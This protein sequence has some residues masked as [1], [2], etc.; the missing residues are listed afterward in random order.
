MATIHGIR[1]FEGLRDRATAIEVAGVP[2]LVAALTDIIRSKRAAGR[3]RD[4]AVLEVLEAARE[5]A[6]ATPS[7]RTPR[8]ARTR[9]SPPAR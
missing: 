9:K 5:E 8:R 3:P 6:E 4:L 7:P 2:V 1:S